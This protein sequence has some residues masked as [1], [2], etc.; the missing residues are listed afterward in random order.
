MQ[1]KVI[2]GNLRQV[3]EVDRDL[4][5]HGD[6]GLTEPT[7]FALMPKPERSRT[8]GTDRPASVR[9]CRRSLRAGLSRAGVCDARRCRSW[10]CRGSR[11]GPSLPKLAWASAAGAL[12][13][14]GVGVDRQARRQGDVGFLQLGGGDREAEE[15]GVFEVDVETRGR[16]GF[17]AG[18]LR[19]EQRLE[20]LA[21]ASGDRRVA[22]CASEKCSGSW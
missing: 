20:E 4:A 8:A 17:G 1:L 2:E 10:R 15:L 7:S 6:S 5:R 22:V 16:V 18:R 12:A 19:V 9:R 3:F 21:F 14:G 11:P 13:V